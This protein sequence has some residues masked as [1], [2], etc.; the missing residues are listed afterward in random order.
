MMNQ[1]GRPRPIQVNEYHDRY[2][3]SRRLSHRIVGDVFPCLVQS[4][5]LLSSSTL[6]YVSKWIHSE[7]KTI[8]HFRNGRSCSLES[9]LRPTKTSLF[10]R[11]SRQ[12]RRAVHG[13][14][15]AVFISR[16]TGRSRNTRRATYILSQLIR[17]AD[18]GDG[19]RVSVFEAR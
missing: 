13:I 19:A 15:L 2:G 12:E 5:W 18:H 11:L 8:R 3:T 10:C 17:R 9:C 4:L 16:R 1:Q 6:S 14:S 7:S